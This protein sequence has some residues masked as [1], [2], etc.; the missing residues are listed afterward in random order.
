M[1]LTNL[2]AH[3]HRVLAFMLRAKQ[4]APTKPMVPDEKTRI[5]RAKLIFEEAMET[6][7]ALGVTVSIQ[8]KRSG[9]CSAQNVNHDEDVEYLFQATREPNLV[10]IVDGC[11]DISVVTIGTLL[12]CGVEDVPVLE[13]VD[14]SNL[15]KFGPGHSYREDGKL[16]KSPDFVK[17]DFKDVLLK[18]GYACPESTSPV[19]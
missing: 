14:A 5:L 9:I 12:A 3:A 15:G 7:D 17:P 6:I 4:A 19:V 13:C 10:E 18:Q 2:T 11:A 16:I 1:N 8:S